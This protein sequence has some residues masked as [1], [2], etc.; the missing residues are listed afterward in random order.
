MLCQEQGRETLAA[1]GC[2]PR[3]P[4]CGCTRPL[5]GV[6]LEITVQPVLPELY[7][8]SVLA[9]AGEG[10]LA[11]KLPSVFSSTYSLFF[12]GLP[13]RDETPGYFREGRDN[14]SF[15]F[16]LADIFFVFYVTLLY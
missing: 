15:Y 11:G 1:A 7:L 14:C 9:E 5:F 4:V 8:V 2:S 12:Q 3:S 10:H 16:H 13:L 6:L